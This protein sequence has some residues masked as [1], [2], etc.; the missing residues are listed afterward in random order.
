MPEKFRMVRE[1]SWPLWTKPLS[2]VRLRISAAVT[3]SVKTG[4]AAP[5]TIALLVY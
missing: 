2:S 3:F 4:S 5:L 1:K